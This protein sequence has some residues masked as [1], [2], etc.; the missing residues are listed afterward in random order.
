[1][2]RTIQLAIVLFTIFTGSVV[3][4]FLVPAGSLAVFTRNHCFR[5]SFGTVLLS[6]AQVFG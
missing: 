5:L 6:D 1:M 3:R 2:E 4:D